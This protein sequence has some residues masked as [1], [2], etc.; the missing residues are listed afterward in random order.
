M[1]SL[2]VQ[3]QLLVQN[4]TLAKCF[5]RIGGCLIIPTTLDFYAEIS[6]PLLILRTA[7][8]RQAAASTS[9]RGT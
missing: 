9:H 3:N 2:L 1:V 4:N 5:G 8:F 7:A 6:N